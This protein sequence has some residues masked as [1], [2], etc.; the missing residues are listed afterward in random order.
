MLKIPKWSDGNTHPADTVA[1][2]TPLC[3]NK[4]VESAIMKE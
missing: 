1:G 3:M 2:S 4:G